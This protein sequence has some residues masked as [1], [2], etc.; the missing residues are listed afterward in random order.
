MNVNL[1]TMMGFS[2]IILV[3]HDLAYAL[4][5]QESHARGTIDPAREKSRS[6]DEILKESWGA[7]AELPSLS[8][9]TQR[10]V[11]S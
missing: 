2:T 8:P 7:G 4:G 10:C 3:G 11:T 5:S 1:A 6:D 9:S